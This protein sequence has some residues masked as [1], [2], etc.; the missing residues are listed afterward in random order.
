MFLVF[1]SLRRLPHSRSKKKKYAAIGTCTGTECAS[2]HLSRA[3][4]EGRKIIFFIQFAL[5]VASSLVF[6]LL[7][8]VACLRHAKR[9]GFHCAFDGSRQPNER[10]LRH[11]AAR[12]EFSRA[13]DERRE[14]EKKVK[15]HLR[16]SWARRSVASRQRGK[17][18]QVAL[19]SV[20]VSGSFVFVLHRGDN[21]LQRCV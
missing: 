7:Q 15:L 1:P 9:L 10:T 11:T 12:R 3:H 13:E 21:E 20:K 8:S 19:S 14:R 16:C 18:S 6:C 17:M 5:K 4:F 2:F